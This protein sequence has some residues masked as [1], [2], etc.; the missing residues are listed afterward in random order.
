MFPLQAK[1]LKPEQKDAVGRRTIHIQPLMGIRNSSTLSRSGKS[2][3]I[4]QGGMSTQSLLWPTLCKE[5]KKS[6]KPCLK[7]RNRVQSFSCSACTKGRRSCSHTRRQKRALK[8]LKNK[9]LKINGGTNPSQKN[10]ASSPD[11]VLRSRDAGRKSK[12]KLGRDTTPSPPPLEELEAFDASAPTLVETQT[13]LATSS[14]SQHSAPSGRSASCN[15][16]MLPGVSKVSSLDRTQLVEL[17]DSIHRTNMHL[18]K[19][20]HAAER[21]LWT[22]D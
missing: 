10:K 8:A 7:P 16:Y 22:W 15:T 11:R 13:P 6:R 4:A 14:S 21:R 19:L 9:A 20:Q 3:T 12:G 18:L 17:L 2:A 5:C 1:A